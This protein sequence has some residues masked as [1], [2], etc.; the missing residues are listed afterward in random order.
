YGISCRV[1][2][3]AERF[4]TAS[5]G[6]GLQPRSLEVL[7]DLGV[8]ERILARGTTEIPTRF[9]DRDRVLGE[10][11]LSRSH[12]EVPGV[13]YP[14]LLIIPEWAT[15]GTLRERLLE[16]GGEVALASSLEELHQDQGGVTAVVRNTQTGAAEE[17]SAGYL[18]GCDG[19]HSTV[20]KALGLA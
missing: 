2:E 4:S 18:V 17:I 6:K 11:N 9:Y 15:E 16:L 20:R 12:G 5:R 14:D 3:K 10:L 19:G 1:L 8:A 13:P 7:D